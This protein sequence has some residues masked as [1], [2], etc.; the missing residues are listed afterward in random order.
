MIQGFCFFRGEDIF[1]CHESSFPNLSTVGFF[2]HY[3]SFLQNRTLAFTR[4]YAHV[5]LDTKQKAP[6]IAGLNQTCS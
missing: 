2:N 1:I 4:H 5:H 6:Q 3:N